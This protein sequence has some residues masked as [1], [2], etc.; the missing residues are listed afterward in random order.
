MAWQ[1]CHELVGGGIRIFSDA[2][3]RRAHVR[4]GASHGFH[5]L[6]HVLGRQSVS[7][8][9]NAPRGV[10]ELRD[11]AGQFRHVVDRALLEIKSPAR[12]QLGQH[13]CHDAPPL[14]RQRAPRETQEAEVQVEVPA[15]EAPLNILTDA[16]PTLIPER[17]S[18]AVESGD[19]RSHGGVGDQT[20]NASEQ[21]SAHDERHVCMITPTSE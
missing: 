7:C 8:Q 1:V 14:S 2:K 12:V 19:A 21:G 4:I 9:M 5:Q 10:G 18:L 20:R 3:P 17:L 11:Q 6:P 16:L 15:I 13:R